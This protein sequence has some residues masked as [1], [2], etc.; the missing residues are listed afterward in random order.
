M[1]AQQ[2]GITFSYE[3]LS[4]LPVGIRADETRLRQI[5]INLLGNAVK[6]TNSGGV[7]FKIGWHYGKIRFQIED[8]GVG[9]A[10]ADLHKIFEPFQQVGEHTHKA[11]GTGL[12]L[13]I[14]KR[15]VEMMGG[16]LCVDS[17]L[18]KGSRFW[19]D[20]ALP[21]VAP[22]LPEE[23]QTEPLIIGFA[24]PPCRLFIV[25][26]KWENRSVMVNLLTPLGFQVREATDGQDGLNKV[27]E[28]RPDLIITDLVMPILDGFEL[29]RRLRKMPEFE[30]IPIIAA[31]AS[32]FEY[33]QE[34]SIIVGCND[35][36]AKPFRVEVLLEL[37][38]K[39]LPIKWIYEEPVDTTEVITIPTDT[40]L[41]G[42]T[43]A[44]AERLYEL[45]L[46][47][48]IGGILE[49]LEQL[50]Q[51]NPQI[52]PFTRKIHKLAKSFKEQQIC[53]FVEP[54]KTG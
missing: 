34:K 40:S 19:M 9:I 41:V 36:I 43:P 20:L 39:H 38:S 45:A 42:P 6:F 49:E 26:D 37:L 1:R 30:Q 27:L 3:P 28:A 4:P 25:D 46:M 18:G 22:L 21:E 47:G 7:T 5:L 35:F 17:D 51:A 16:E 8:T 50:E 15:L 31:S 23:N 44:Q 14:T 32:V 10:K 13:P 2:K 33:H 12:G 48:D 11:E 54:Y 53:E 24:G 52:L 29:V